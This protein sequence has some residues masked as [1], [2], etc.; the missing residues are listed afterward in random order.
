MKTLIYL[1]LIFFSLNACARGSKRPDF[2]VREERKDQDKLW[3]PCQD[4]EASEPIGK[5][6]NKVCIKVKH[7]GE[8]KEWK[9]NV[10][11]FAEKESFNFYRDAGF[12]L[13]DE[14]NL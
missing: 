2:D 1:T 14:D 12:V 8:C 3:R 9:I 13:I 7:S 10:K 11:N 5:V 6:C 4:S